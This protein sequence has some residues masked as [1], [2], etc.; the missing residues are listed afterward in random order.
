MNSEW[1][2]NLIKQ[3]SSGLLKYLKSHTHSAED[4]EDILQDVFVSVYEHSAEFDPERCNEQA[5]LY[6]IAKR[7]LV[8]YYRKH[9]TDE[10]LDAME[11]WEVPGVDSMA[12]ATNVMS[13]RQAVARALSRLDE[14]SRAIVVMRY[15]DGLDSDEIAARMNIST[16]NARTILSRALD[17]MEKELGDY[18]FT[19]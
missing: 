4:A 10:S 14:R 15:F 9:K 19:E 18:D 13:A 1:T 6:I 12:K 16:A 7:K 17:T 8:D 2:E 3:Y 11:D 5:W